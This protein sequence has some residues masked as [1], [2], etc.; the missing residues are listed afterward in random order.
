MRGQAA[1]KGF[2]KSDHALEG[3]VGF[4]AEELGDIGLADAELAGEVGL[5]NSPAGH[6]L[7]RLLGEIHAG[8]LDLV[9]ERVAG[10]GE[11]SLDAGELLSGF[12]HSVS[13]CL[14]ILASR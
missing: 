2:G 10:M 7:K 13:I 8:G 6:D 1:I 12:A 4:P 14:D 11:D 3:E 9:I 5:A